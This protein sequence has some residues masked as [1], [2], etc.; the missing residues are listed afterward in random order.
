MRLNEITDFSHCR[1]QL[2]DML[3]KEKPILPWQ[4]LYIHNNSKP[5]RICEKEIYLMFSTDGLI[6]LYFMH[7]SYKKVMRNLDT[8]L[9]LFFNTDIK[10]IQKEFIEISE[11]FYL[12]KENVTFQIKQDMLTV[13]KKYNN[14]LRTRLKPYECRYLLLLSDLKK[15]LR[16]FPDHVEAPPKEFQKYLVSP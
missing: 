9:V 11:N 8:E 5:F 1:Q 10:N 16:A 6:S 7:T 12:D 13:L 3:W 4:I 2:K 15:Y 14:P